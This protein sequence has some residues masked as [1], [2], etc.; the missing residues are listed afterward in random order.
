V[1]RGPVRGREAGSRAL[2]R[3]LTVRRLEVGKRLSDP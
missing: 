3:L 1:P 2:G